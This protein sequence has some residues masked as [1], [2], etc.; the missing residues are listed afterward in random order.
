MRPAEESALDL[1]VIVPVLDE[2][3]SVEELARRVVETLAPSG[4]SSDHLRR[5][6]IAGRD[7][8]PD[9]GGAGA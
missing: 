9:P 6:R 2:A 8:G 7:A 4:R 1:S 3:E 5:R